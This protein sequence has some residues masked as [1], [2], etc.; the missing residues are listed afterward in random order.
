MTRFFFAHISISCY[1][2]PLKNWCSCFSQILTCCVSFS[3]KY[4][5][6]LFLFFNPWLSISKY[7]WIFQIAFCYFFPC[8]FAVFGF[9]VCFLGDHHL[10]LRRRH[11]SEPALYVSNP[12]AGQLMGYLDRT[13]AGGQVYVS[14]VGSS[15]LAG[16][17]EMGPAL[18]LL[19]LCSS[20]KTENRNLL[21]VSMWGNHNPHPI[22]HYVP[23]NS[24]SQASTLMQETESSSKKLNGPE[25]SMVLDLN[26]LQKE[27][28]VDSWITMVDE[29]KGGGDHLWSPKHLLQ[30]QLLHIS[31]FLL[32]VYIHT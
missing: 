1:K 2:F 25:K 22:H 16:V 4:F 14:T 26:S 30:R 9:L 18:L 29:Y 3:S 13:S 6:I 20:S 10:S 32:V 15:L 17:W 12:V 31:H 7:L 5:L 8:I 19:L 21:K 28:R 24:G 11:W 27:L 23:K